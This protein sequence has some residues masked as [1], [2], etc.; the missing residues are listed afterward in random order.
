MIHFSG[1][2]CSICSASSPPL[3][4]RMSFNRWIRSSFARSC[5]LATSGSKMGRC[6]LSAGPKLSEALTRL[7]I[8][9]KYKS[10]D[11]D[12]RHICNRCVFYLTIYATMLLCSTGGSFG[13]NST[14]ETHTHKQQSN[15][16]NNLSTS[17]TPLSQQSQAV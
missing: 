4:Q 16:V 5:R 12:L 13:S 11:F 9:A 2:R 6:L 3:K 14:L 15:I 8:A 10:F 17:C 7:S 1:K